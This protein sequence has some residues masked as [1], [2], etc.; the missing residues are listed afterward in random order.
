M[1]R[2]LKKVSAK[3][4]TH[5]M[6]LRLRARRE[7]TDSAGKERKA[8]EEWMVRRLGAYM[9][10]VDEEIV[11]TVRA[12]VL[13]EKK[14]LHLRADRSFTDVY[15]KE[16]KAGEEWLVMFE[17][18]ETHIKDVS[19]TVVAEVDIT[20][21]TSRQ[22]CVIL[23]PYV[24]GVQKLGTR[25]LVRGECSFFLQPGEKLENDQI[26]QVHVLAED[27]A[28]LL[29]AVEAFTDASPPAITKRGDDRPVERSPGDLWMIYGPCEYVPSVTVDLIE[30]IYIRD[31]KSG[32]VRAVI[33]STYMLKPT[34]QLWDKPLADDVEALLVKQALGQ[35]YIAPEDRG[36]S[37]SRRASAKSSGRNKSKVV[38]FQVPHNA[39]C[40]VYDY[41]Q[42]T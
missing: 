24:D 26:E 8:G 11:E 19:E 1:V 30:G 10:G 20:T 13:T 27:E 36:N 9:P 34:E 29:T 7:C 25:K 21:L 42:K 5:D 3:V 31:I 16:R 17:M 33:G 40:Q 23:D 32:K 15:G 14:A 22:Y 37:R 28:L 35:A 4:I 6:G 18:A 2:R 38:T 12:Y 39:A 41:K